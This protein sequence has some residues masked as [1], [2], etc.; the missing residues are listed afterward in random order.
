MDVNYFKTQPL[1]ILK[2]MAEKY[3]I[4]CTHCR[5]AI[6]YS[7]TKLNRNKVAT[8]SATLN[9]IIQEQVLIE[10]Q[11]EF[12]QRLIQI[13]QEHNQQLQQVYNNAGDR[14]NI[15]PNIKNMVL[16]SKANDIFKQLENILNPLTPCCNVA[17]E[18]GDDECEAVTCIR[19]NVRFCGLCL[20]RE[21]CVRIAD[22]PEN[23]QCPVHFHVTQCPENIDFRGKYFTVPFYPKF[24]SYVRFGETWN[25]LIAFTENDDDLIDL[26]KDKIMPLI[27][28]TNIKFEL[29]DGTATIDT[30]GKH[31]V[32]VQLTIEQK[33]IIQQI[34]RPPPVE[35]V[36]V[37]RRYQVRCGLCRALGH[38]RR[39]CPDRE[40]LED[41]AYHD[42]DNIPIDDYREII[43]LLEDD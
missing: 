34:F 4:Q 17:F 38:N 18:Y 11:K 43:D 35:R 9:T 3:Y 2:D 30:L 21:T 13:R 14:E 37:R 27:D 8:I 15:D 23:R 22:I 19:C 29:E 42:D 6:P 31:Y 25:N 28:G 26:L 33:A 16:Q 5:Y 20:Q 32:D 1:E 12:E 10:K 36:R 24:R 41:V 40:R 39:R 7:K